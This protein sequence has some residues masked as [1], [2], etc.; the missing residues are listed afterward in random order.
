MSWKAMTLIG[1]VLAAASVVAGSALGTNEENV[2]AADSCCAGP[3][4]PAGMKMADSGHEHGK[5]AAPAAKDEKKDADL[6]ALQ[7][8]SYPVETCVV[9]GE[10]LGGDMGE[11][12]DYFYKNRLVRFCCKGCVAKFEKEPEK[13][14]AKLDSAVIDKEKA[15]Y[16]LDTCV[17]SGDKLGGDMGEPI[18]YVVANR[19]VRLCCKGC[20]KEIE[21]DPAKYI[22]K[23]DAARGNAKPA[24]AA[25]GGPAN[26]D[27]E[28][29]GEHSEHGGTHDG[30]AG[31]QH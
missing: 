19:L 9:S 11:P 10:K 15:D 20:I 28:P 25:P 8:E 1:I 4:A 13:Y 7:K 24:A 27:P 29:T 3:V 12:V 31:H 18:D 2:A 21:K 23:V 30:H 6:S 5:T 17:V 26:P 22:L 14:L 16:P